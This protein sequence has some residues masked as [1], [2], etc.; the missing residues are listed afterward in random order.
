MDNV[1][2]ALSKTKNFVVQHKTAIAV[3]ATATAAVVII[4]RN[5]KLFNEF[6]DEKG[7]M[8]EYYKTPEA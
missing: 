4:R 3:A 8:D 2:N 1:K 6:L 7:L 5:Q